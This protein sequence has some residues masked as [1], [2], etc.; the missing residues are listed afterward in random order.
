MVSTFLPAT[1][2]RR[3]ISTAVDVERES[4]RETDVVG[5]TVSCNSCN[6]CS[7]PI[8]LLEGLRGVLRIHSLIYAFAFLLSCKLPLY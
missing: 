6:G 5:G 2:L 7:V 4:S 1:P 8:R 3:A